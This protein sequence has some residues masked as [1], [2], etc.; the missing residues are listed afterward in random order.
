MV[1]AG[2]F[3]GGGVNKLGEKD[4]R[5]TRNKANSII[6][7]LVLGWPQDPI[8]VASLGSSAATNP[9]K[10][11]KVDLL[12]SGARLD[13]RQQTDGL[14]VVLPGTYRPAVDYAAALKVTL[15]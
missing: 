14:R 3:Q 5:F 9:G 12:G 13:W 8:V 6:Y 7:A 4:I 10:V 11:A 15:S 1:K 2:S